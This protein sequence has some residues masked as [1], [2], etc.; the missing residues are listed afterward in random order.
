MFNFLLGERASVSTFVKFFVY[1]FFKYETMLNYGDA[2]GW[3]ESRSEGGDVGRE[4][5]AESVRYV[6][7]SGV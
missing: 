4:T 2:V 3:G 7:V 1:N 6:W 5:K